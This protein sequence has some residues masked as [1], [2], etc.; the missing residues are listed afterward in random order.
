ML[1]IYQKLLGQRKQSESSRR[2]T[3]IFPFFSSVVSSCK[4]TISTHYR[5]PMPVAVSSFSFLHKTNLSKPSPPL[6]CRCNCI[7]PTKYKQFTMQAIR[8]AI[9]LHDSHPNFDV[10]V[11]QAPVCYIRLLSTPSDYQ[12]LYAYENSTSFI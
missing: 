4:M 12:R 7:F 5:Y 11:N 10:V 6:G 3:S 8:L 9:Y 2:K 1:E